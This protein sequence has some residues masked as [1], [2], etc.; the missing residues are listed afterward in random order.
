MALQTQA[1]ST[2]PTLTHAPSRVVDTAPVM[3]SRPSSMATTPTPNSSQMRCVVIEL[4]AACLAL[5]RLAKSATLLYLRKGSTRL[6][7]ACSVMTRRLG[8]NPGRLSQHP[9][10]GACSSCYFW[11]TRAEICCG[12]ES[13]IDGGFM[14]GN[15]EGEKDNALIFLNVFLPG[16]FNGF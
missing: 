5:P 7:L 13:S 8:H 3:C 10:V 14:G 9:I 2:L 16:V 4:F 15:S 11:G 1:A 12:L 6:F